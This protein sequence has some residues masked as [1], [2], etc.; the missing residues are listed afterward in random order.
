MSTSHQIEAVYQ[1]ALRLREQATTT[2]IDPSLLDLALKAPYLVLEELQARKEQMTVA[3][4]TN[5]LQ[6]SR[7][8]VTTI[9]W[10]LRDTSQQCCIEQ[11]LLATQT[12]LE[13]LVAAHTAALFETNAQLRQALDNCCQ[14][15]A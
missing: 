14:G 3:I 5:I 10:S 4:A 8:G 7:H 13:A 6:D 9:L 2:T 1:R 11:Q 12:D 15:R